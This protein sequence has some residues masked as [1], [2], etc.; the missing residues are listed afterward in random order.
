MNKRTI[1]CITLTSVVAALLLTGA[2]VRAANSDDVIASAI[3]ESYVYATY[4]K[5]DDIKTEVKDGV[6]TLSGSVAAES[7]KALAQ[8]TAENIDGVARVDN[9]LETKAEIASEHADTWMGR[10]VKLALL[11]HRNVHASATTVTVKDG[12]VTLSGVASSTA[13]K[14]LTTEYAKD[15]DGVTAVIN[16]MTIASAPVAAE[17]TP[18]QKIDDASVTAQVKAGLSTH[19]STSG[20]A[21]QVT[22]R[23]GKVTLTGIA[24]NDAEKALVTKL[25]TDIQGVSSV[26]NEMTVAAAKTN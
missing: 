15:I 20:V 25:V 12:V 1:T 19:K 22:T 2:P 16:Q 3:K 11:F 4:L 24:G 9:Q 6:V 21:T 7:H 18:G 10:K 14:D 13:Q 26:N 5:E 8:D 23:D 17:R